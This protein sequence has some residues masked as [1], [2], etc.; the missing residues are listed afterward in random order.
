MALEIR[1]L[2]VNHLPNGPFPRSKLGFAARICISPLVK[3]QQNGESIQAEW[4]PGALFCSTPHGIRRLFV[5]SGH[6]SWLKKYGT[7]AA[8]VLQFSRI[9]GIRVSSH[10]VTWGPWVF[11]GVIGPG[12]ARDLVDFPGPPAAKQRRHGTKTKDRQWGRR[13]WWLWRLRRWRGFNA[14]HPKHVT[15]CM[16]KMSV[17]DHWHRWSLGL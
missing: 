2:Q 10:L 14:G 8:Y 11:A 15:W 12:L 17:W 13:L 5:R 1:D 3:I 4:P 6:A 16:A 9:T 7:S